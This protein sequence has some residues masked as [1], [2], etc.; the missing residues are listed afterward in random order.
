MVPLLSAYA[1]RG[2][3]ELTVALG[4]TGG[5]HRS[6]ALAAELAR[7]LG[8]LEGIDIACRFRELAG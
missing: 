6:V 2:R 4:C 3:M 1:E 5:R 8:R 7:R